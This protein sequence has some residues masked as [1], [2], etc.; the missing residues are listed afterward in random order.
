MLGPL[1]PWA[2]HVLKII[3]K[4][5]NKSSC[6]IHGVSTKMVK[7]IGPEILAPLAHIFNLSLESG[8]FP[9]MLKQCRVISIFKSGSHLECDNYRPISLLSSISKILE[10]IVSEILLH[11]LTSNDLLYT[12]KD[13]CIIKQRVQSLKHPFLFL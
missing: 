3:K 13:L 11:H 7:F 8:I 1:G 12:N 2:E 6:D 10:K 4:L 5:K 9:T